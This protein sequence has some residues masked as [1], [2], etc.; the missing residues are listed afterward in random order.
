MQIYQPDKG[1]SV[2]MPGFNSDLGAGV[3]R[4]TDYGDTWTRVG[5]AMNQAAIFGT[6]QRVYAMYAWA[7]GGCSLDPAL[8]SAP[9]P[10]T[11]RWARMSTP[12]EMA[13]GPAQTATVCDG[14]NFIVL[15]AN[16]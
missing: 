10:G 6:P 2:F 12:P 4:S 14:T 13:I 16:W 1:G 15:T 11:S 3:L 7:C 5:I 8:Q 9:Q